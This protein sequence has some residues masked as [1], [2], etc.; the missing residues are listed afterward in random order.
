MAVWVI[1][2][3]ALITLAVADGLALL[4]LS[5]NQ[6]R[7]VPEVYRETVEGGLAQGRPD[8]AEIG[9]AFEKGIVTVQNPR[10]REKLPGLSQTDSLVVH[11]AQEMRAQEC[12][13]NDQ[14]LLVKMRRRGLVARY[15]L[16]FVE[17]LH[18][19]GRISRA[20]RDRLLREFLAQGRY[21]EPFLQSLLRRG[22][23]WVS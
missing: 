4:T 15:T 7:T 3:S 20:K 9:R 11:L 18:T 14:D 17:A 12:L 16:E 1:D 8:A 19:T 2:S 23:P 22:E 10:R 6:I 5:S 21:T 13:I